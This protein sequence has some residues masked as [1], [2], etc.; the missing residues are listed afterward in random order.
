[1]SSTTFPDQRSR[2]KGSVFI[3]MVFAM[4]ILV[5]AIIR[6]IQSSHAYLAHG[7]EAEQARNCIEKHGVW[8]AYREHR[9]STFHGLCQDP[10]TGTIYDLIVEK[11]MEGRYREK[12][13]FRPKDGTWDAV[14]AWLE[15]K[16]SQ[17]VSPPTE[18]IELITP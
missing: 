14:R 6:V 8:R 15:R 3:F 17:W 10:T 11:L 4:A 18:A 12:T 2:G 1:M 5:Y 13:A 7:P 9:G 16:R